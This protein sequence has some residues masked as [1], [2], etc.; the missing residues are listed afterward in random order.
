MRLFVRIGLVAACLMASHSAAFA[1]AALSG[2]VKDTSGAVLPGV[3]VEAA[4]PALI[5][6][7]RTAVTDSTGRYRI[8]NL[9]PG[10]YS[11]TFTLAG[12][13]TVKREGV[14][15]SGTGVVNA[16][17]RRGARLPHAGPLPEG[18]GALNPAGRRRWA[19]RGRCRGCRRRP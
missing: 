15:V 16:D 1:Q 8:E 6:K 14:N 4:S 3:T 2:V 18:E 19:R 11:V 12:F 5:E 7:V 17:T 13:V 9:Q 10:A